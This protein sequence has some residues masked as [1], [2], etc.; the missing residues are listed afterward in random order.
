MDLN[1]GSLNPGVEFRSRLLTFQ[2][3]IKNNIPL[4][5]LLLH[6]PS[7][8]HF[9]GAN[10]DSNMCFG[11]ILKDVNVLKKKYVG[12]GCLCKGLWR[13]QLRGTA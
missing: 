3:R 7:D 12:K 11:E 13:S 9:I 10:L 2:F 8:F 6:T 1:Y 4:P 5:P